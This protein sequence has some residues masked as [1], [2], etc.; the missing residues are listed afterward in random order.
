[1][2]TSKFVSAPDALEILFANRNKAYGAYQLRREYPVNLGKALGIGLLLIFA[3]IFLP[4]LL[5]ALAPVAVKNQAFDDDRKITEVHIEKTPVVPIPPTPKPP[6]RTTV[7]FKPP[8]ITDD[9]TPDNP[10]KAV[11]VLLASK[12]EIGKADH[13]G[14]DDAPPAMKS[15]GLGNPT[16]VIPTTPP[17]DDP[18]ELFDVQKLPSFPGGEQELLKYLASNIKYPDL[19]REMGIEG[20]VAISFVINKNGS[21]GDIQVLKDIGGGCSKEAVRVIK[22]M[23]NWMPGEAN[24]HTV[25]VHLTLPVRFKLN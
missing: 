15:Y 19:A 1:M 11:D 17:P 8:V 12:A 9:F 10:P 20:V 22:S 23:P 3:A 6:V 4:R 16:S 18:V 21:I 5:Q 7:A 14:D 2:A 24:G 13:S 25:R